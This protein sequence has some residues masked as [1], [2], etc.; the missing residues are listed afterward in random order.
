MKSKTF[1]VIALF[2]LCSCQKDSGV[3]ST[4]RS[5][6]AIDY[7]AMGINT[8]GWSAQMVDSLGRV[9][10]S[11][12][13]TLSV[14]VAG[15]GESVGQYSNLICL[16][17]SSSHGEHGTTR[18][19]YLQSTDSLT[20]IAYAGAGAVPLSLPKTSTA[21]TSFRL[22]LPVS[23]QRILAGRAASDSVYLRD[24]VRIVHR[25]PFTIGTRWAS[26][27]QP[28]YSERE[29]V[30]YESVTVKAG[31]FSCYKIKTTIDLGGAPFAME[32]YD[33]VAQQGIVLRTLDFPML[34]L[35]TED[36]PDGTGWVSSTERL[37]LLSIY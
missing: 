13:D 21:S 26:F 24:E 25:Y 8:Y 9:L 34:L 27:H 37:E 30:G 15:T 31:T 23:L 1:L 20:E 5:P 4:G 12:S 29:V 17:A 2:S 32:W 6:Y 16:E 33:F 28:F 7:L 14:R 3:Q 11:D 36:H 35:T 22:S 19:W 10:D 18:S